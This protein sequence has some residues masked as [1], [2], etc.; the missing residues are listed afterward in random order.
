MI[1]TSILTLVVIT[2]FVFFWGLFAPRIEETARAYD[3]F[4]QCIASSG[5]EFYGTHMC[6]TCYEQKKIFG[7]AGKKLPYIECGDGFN[8]GGQLQVCHQKGIESYPTWIF[9]DGR[10]KE[11]VLSKKQLSILTGCEL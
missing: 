9:P 8:F 11:G 1:R 5:A 6:D 3:T 4:A 2:S 7:S 10:R